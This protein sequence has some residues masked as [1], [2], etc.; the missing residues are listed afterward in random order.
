MN[1]KNELEYFIANQ[2]R[3]VEQYSDKVLVIKGQQV[4][5]AYDLALEA[6][7]EAQKEHKLGTFMI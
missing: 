7:I 6:Y 2:D 1:F 3:L 5:G 4:V